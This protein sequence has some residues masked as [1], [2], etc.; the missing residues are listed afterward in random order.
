MARTVIKKTSSD[1]SYTY[2]KSLLSEVDKK[3]VM[4][5]ENFSIDEAINLHKIC[6]NLESFFF[7]LKEELLEQDFANDYNNLFS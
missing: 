2:L 1:G 5:R 6:R 3:S 4:R 7:V